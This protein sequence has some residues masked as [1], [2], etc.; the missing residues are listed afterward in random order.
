MQHTMAEYEVTAQALDPTNNP[1]RPNPDL[2]LRVQFMNYP[3]LDQA[4]SSKEARPIYK[5]A[6]YIYI[7][8]PGERDVVHR[9]AWDKDYERFPRQH[10]AFLNKQNQDTASGTPLK[11]V[12][13]LSL[14]QV[15]ELEFF[16]C[17]TLEQLASMPDS[18]ATKFLAIQKLKQLAKDHLQAAKE[19]APLT[20]M[21]A[22]MDEKDSRIQALEN[23][24]QDIIKR[25]PAKE[26]D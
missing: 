15:K 5:E 26:E 20:A 24:L 22:E 21:R 4:A 10:Q 2:R 17:Y 13:W 3:E 25:L 12:A 23:Q 7:M 1:D 16:N 8:V 6:V 9:R 14:G 11:H 19:A 18:Q